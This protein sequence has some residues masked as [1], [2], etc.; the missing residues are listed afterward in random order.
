MSSKK[1]S[2]LSTAASLITVA[3]LSPVL[4][5]AQL[6]EVVVTAQK[7]QE[8]LQDVPVSVA[9]VDNQRLDDSQFRD[10]RAILTLVPSVNF[11]HGF[12]PAATNFNIRGLGSFTFTEGI[13]PGVSL[14]VDGVPRARNGEFVF[15]LADIEQ[16]E[17]LRGPQGTLYG[18][19]STGGAINITT[20]SPTDEFYGE[21]EVGAS[22]DEEYFF[23][24]VISGPLSDNIRGRFAG[25]YLDREGYLEN[26]GPGPDLAGQE[27]IAARVKLDIDASDSVTVRLTA[28]Y[29]KNEHGFYPLDGS[30]GT[31]TRTD[32]VGGVV[33][34]FAS[35]FGY[36]N[37]DTAKFLALGQ[38]DAALGQ[39]ILNDPFK[40]ALDL[41]NDD[42]ENIIWGLAATLNWEINESLQLVSITSYREFT[43]DN[44]VDTDTTPAG[45]SNL[46]L[47]PFITVGSTNV[48][49]DPGLSFQSNHEYFQQEIRLE[50]SEERFDWIVGGFYQTL[51]ERSTNGRNYLFDIS[52]FA[53]LPPGSLYNCGVCDAADNTIDQETLAAF[54]DITFRVNDRLD[55]FGGVRYTQ[56]D[57]DKTMNNAGF[58]GVVAGAQLLA[59]SD[60]NDRDQV[61]DLASITGLAGSGQPLTRMPRAVGSASESFDFTSFRVGLNYSVTDD[62]NVYAAVSR[63]NV[64][65]AIPVAV[66]DVLVDV[67]GGQTAFLDPTEADNIEI[68]IKSELLDNR[69]R[70][71]LAVFDMDVTDIQ[72]QQVL[73]GTISAVTISGGDLESQ[74]FELD[75]TYLATD[76]LTLSAGLVH[77]DAEIQG[78]LQACYEDQLAVGLVP[79]CTIDGNNDG[80]PD[81]QDVSG[82][83]TTNT[84]EWSYN[85][86]AA[87]SFP[88]DGLSASFYGNLNYSWRDDKQYNLNQ[89]DLLIQD[90][91]G[92]LDITLGLR[93]KDGRYDVYLYG[94]NVTDEYFF[95]Y[96]VGFSNF[97]D[98][99]TTMSLR[100]AQAYYGIGAKFFF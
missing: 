55:I 36:P 4:V 67:P 66:N 18:R 59:L 68:G 7:R 2:F 80:T 50:G 65:P 93:D 75:A 78:L 43:N 33:E 84:P 21:V 23:R 77:T 87:V 98:R 13:Q 82:N 48:P 94:K 71:N 24:G 76:W 45:L 92:I 47:W 11:Q 73:P 86:N 61:V 54:A 30:F 91:Y 52:S 49:Q 19:G 26:L 38:G 16:I 27:T 14:S 56:E 72:T 15:D 64:G 25:M 6:E 90:S 22:D 1:A 34:N 63:G 46:G 3:S 85:L 99:V 28:D 32:A 62:V 100:N 53:A 97:F 42:Q 41:D 58:V 8:S 83:Q 5:Q 17:V 29:S 69:L 95:N 44:A 40:V 81:T 39:Q 20:A 57:V 12:T 96:A 89:D 37:P 35:V 31:L 10:F 60:P 74:G 51:D 88:V 9:V 79:G 70:L